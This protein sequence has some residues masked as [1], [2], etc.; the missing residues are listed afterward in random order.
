[1]LQRRRAERRV[2]GTTLALALAIGSVLA[3]SSPS[4]ALPFTLLAPVVLNQLGVVGT[5]NPVLPLPPVGALGLTAGSVNLGF[6]GQDVF[7]VDITL[8]AGSAPVDG[9]GITVGTPSFFVGNP[10]GI[11]SFN[12]AGDVAPTSVF[13][14]QFFNFAGLFTFGTPIAAGQNS[15]RLFVTYE[16]EGEMAI[17]QIVNFMVS[18]G[19]DFTVQGILVPEPTTVLML[20]LGLAGLGFIERR[21][22]RAP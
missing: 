19:T 3:S 9:L 7:V 20:G 11:G 10:A 13:P 16:P 15:V 5:I 2:L 21:T 22:R 4:Q 1:M 6:A 12:D 14:D 8:G 18:S 17:G